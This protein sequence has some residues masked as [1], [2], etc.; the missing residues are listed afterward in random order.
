[1]KQKIKIFEII[2]FAFLFIN[3][4]SLAQ[5][6]NNE[7]FDIEAATKIVEQRSKEFEDALKIADSLAVGDI[8]TLDTKVVG[9]Y[10]G[11]NNLI[12]EVHEMVQD[13]ITGIKFRIFY[14]WG[15]ENIII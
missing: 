14:L 15:N 12:N 8:Y 5:N 9:A 10:S 13:S 1:M 6:K 2:L 11:R 7:S 4:K 3:V